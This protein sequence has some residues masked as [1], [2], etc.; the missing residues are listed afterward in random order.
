MGF[1]ARFI[2][3]MPTISIQSSI[4]KP[5]LL[6]M[7]CVD[8]H[9]SAPPWVQIHCTGSG[10]VLIKHCDAV[11]CVSFSNSL[12]RKYAICAPSY[13]S[14]RCF[15]SLMLIFGTSYSIEILRCILWKQR[16]SLK[17][18]TIIFRLS[19]TLFLAPIIPYNGWQFC[20]YCCFSCMFDFFEFQKYVLCFHGSQLRSS[21]SIEIWTIQ[22]FS[23]VLISWDSS[24]MCILQQETK[25]EWRNS[26]DL[27]CRIVLYPL[28]SL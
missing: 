26:Y 27:L 25:L 22:T 14:D 3:Q 5:V 8:D 24:Q 11:K 15:A 9:C 17:S 1:I 4:D 7:V 19:C 16:I 21:C 23:S 6:H 12:M 18:W 10:I 2:P 13:F 20:C 28:I